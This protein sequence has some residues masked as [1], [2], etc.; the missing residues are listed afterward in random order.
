[1]KSITIQ[2]RPRY[3][4]FD[5]PDG[6]RIRDQWTHEHI[7]NFEGETETFPKYKDARMACNTLNK[8]HF[9]FI[10]DFIDTDSYSMQLDLF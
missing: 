9:D 5:H 10:K 4:I 1:M 2:I 3:K 7:T 8:T 6:W